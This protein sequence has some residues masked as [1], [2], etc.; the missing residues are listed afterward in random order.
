MDMETMIPLM[1]FVLLGLGSWGFIKMIE[2]QQ[3][4]E[5]KNE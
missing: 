3:R 4:K 1:V 2:I 5:K